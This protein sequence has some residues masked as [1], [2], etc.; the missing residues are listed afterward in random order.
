MF[1]KILK[2][3]P[4]KGQRKFRR[5]QTTNGNFFALYCITHSSEKIKA[6]E[7]YKFFST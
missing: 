2:V 1:E 7:E 5:I 3:S 6:F 4:V